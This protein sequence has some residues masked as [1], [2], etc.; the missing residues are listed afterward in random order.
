MYKIQFK[1]YPLF[2]LLAFGT[3]VL[4][5]AQTNKKDF[6]NTSEL[7]DSLNKVLNDHYVFP[8]KAKSIGIYF[9]SQL[10][11]NVYTRELQNPQK[12][13]EQIQRDINKIHRD[14]HMGIKYDPG[15]HVQ[16]YIKPSEEE[17]NRTKKYWKENNYAFSK[18]EILPGN[19]G[20]FPFN[21]FVDDIESAKPTISSALRFLSNTSAIIIDLRENYGGSPAMVSQIESFFFKEK[22]HMNDLINRSAK[23]TTFFYADPAKADSLNLLMPVYI[24]TSHN[25]FSGGE[26]F[27]YGM[28]KANRAIIVGETTGG[29]A[30]PQKPFSVGQGFVISIPYARSLNP[31]TKTDWEGTGVI[32]DVKEKAQNAL[33]TAQQLIF[34]NQM[35]IAK[36]E[37]EK[38]KSEFNLYS[39]LLK[40]EIKNPPLS[41]LSQLIGTYPD[42][43]IYLDKGKLLCKNNDD[44]NVSELKQI[45]NNRFKIDKNAQIE[46]FKT[47]RG[48]FSSIKIYLSDGNIFEEAKK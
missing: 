40:N 3:P 47:N 16:Q 12:L 35:L 37:K 28:Q 29:G 1:T 18:L 9:E 27:S 30:H 17:V 5:S 45:A 2:F 24:L 21:V 39:L 25:T 6:I 41:I 22:T 26:D 4:C 34:K 20:Y 36:D 44:K 8:N 23:D 32:P 13:A 31:V 42:V 15:F 38:N 7:V 43:T 11:D 46:F 10:K 33:L 48:Q 14:P 19:I